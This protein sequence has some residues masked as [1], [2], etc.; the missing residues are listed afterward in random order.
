MGTLAFIRDGDKVLMVHRTFK[1]TD[2]NLGK[3]NGIGGKV[4]YGEN[5]DEGMR[6]EIKE[7]TG[8]DVID[9][10]MRGTIVWRDFGPKKEDWLVFVFVVDEFS[11]F[12]FSENDEGRL[13]WVNIA[14]IGNL[15]MWKGDALF[16]P[17]LFDGDERLFHG[18]MRYDGEEPVEWRVSGRRKEHDCKDGKEERQYGHP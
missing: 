17:L 1:E 16:L 10:K 7:E 18:Y 4:E 15:P 13:S 2:E 9:M 8:L 11:G 3:W 12:P 14:D 6:R 5:I